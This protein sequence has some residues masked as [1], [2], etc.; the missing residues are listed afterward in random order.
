[1]NARTTLKGLVSCQAGIGQIDGHVP[2]R[3]TETS[4]HEW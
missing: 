3:P 1:M 4:S 2:L